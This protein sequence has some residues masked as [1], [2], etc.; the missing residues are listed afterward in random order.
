MDIRAA[1]KVA[2]ALGPRMGV[3]PKVVATMLAFSYAFT[4][5]SA[6]T[7]I[8]TG[9]RWGAARSASDRGRGAR[10]RQAGDGIDRRRAVF[11]D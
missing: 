9:S 10:F 6:V 1:N 11:F 4:T 3:T 5:S 7:A 2:T 8:A